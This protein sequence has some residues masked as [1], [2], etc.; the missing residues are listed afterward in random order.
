[1]LD[2]WEFVSGT[3]FEYAGLPAAAIHDACCVA[4]L[5]DS[6]VFT[7]EKAHVD[8]ELRGDWTRGMT[9]TNFANGPGMRHTGIG[10]YGLGDATTDVAM[11]LDWPRF[12]DIIVDSIRTL[13]EAKQQR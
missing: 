5:A 6:K 3:H 9:V 12:A 2:I 7:T 8:V 4:Y 11:Q 10:G 1:M 13:T